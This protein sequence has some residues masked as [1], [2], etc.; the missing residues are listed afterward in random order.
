VAS[1]AIKANAFGTH[2]DLLR[3]FFAAGVEGF[4]SGMEGYLQHEGGLAD[5]RLAAQQAQ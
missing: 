3:A 4:G 2:S 1:G 5:S